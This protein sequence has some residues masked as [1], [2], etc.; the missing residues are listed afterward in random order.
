MSFRVKLRGLLGYSRSK[1]AGNLPETYVGSLDPNH[2]ETSHIDMK[3]GVSGYIHT[4][5]IKR[6]TF[7]LFSFCVELGFKCTLDWVGF[8]ALGPG[9]GTEAAVQRGG[10]EGVSHVGWRDWHCMTT[11]TRS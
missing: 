9:K 11:Q 8:C 1:N 7:P 10:N 6:H 4:W 3:A 5:K 2:V